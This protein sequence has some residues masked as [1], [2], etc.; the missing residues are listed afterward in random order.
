MFTR[1][2]ATAWCIG[3]LTCFVLQLLVGPQSNA[4]KTTTGHLKRT[5]DKA[6]V[7]HVQLR[8][9][10]A[11]A[12]E[13]LLADWRPVANYCLANEPFLFSYEIAQSDKNPLLFSMYERYRS[14]TDYLERHKASAAF[15]AF[16]EKMKAMQEAGEVAVSGESFVELG[17]GFV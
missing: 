13:R 10:T 6:F 4:P 16:R 5:N 14:K 8:F 11:S 12:A 17:V 15:L 3:M 7:L 9:T 1:E 2:H